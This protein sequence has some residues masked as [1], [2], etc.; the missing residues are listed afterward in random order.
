MLERAA[1][2]TIIETILRTAPAAAGILLALAALVAPATSHALAPRGGWRM[3]SDGVSG[4][5]P[6]NVDD[7]G[8][9]LMAVAEVAQGIEDGIDFTAEKI[10]V[11]LA[12]KRYTREA[13]ESNA[14]L[15]QFLSYNEG[16]QIKNSTDFGVN[17]RLPNLEKKWQLRFSSFDEREEERRTSQR[18]IRTQP[19][20]KEYGAAVRFFRQLGNVKA[21]FQPRLELR[22]PLEMS[23][24]LRFESVGE[25]KRLRVAPKLEL[26]ADAEKGT[27]QYG[28]FNVNYDL[29]KVWELLFI[30]DEEYRDFDNLLTVNNGASISRHLNDQMSAGATLM[31]LS[32]NR[33]L[34]NLE[35]YTFAPGFSHILAVD[36]IRYVISPYIIFARMNSWK[37]VTGIS[38]NFDVTF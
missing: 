10:D 4:N 37:G 28:S 35:Q 18:Y 26:F 14:T 30:N 15:T 24:I 6:N 22:D 23:Y 9:M 3:S 29:T 27:G 2:G 31:F 8:R 36:R 16:G 17:L 38:V 19:R 7:T 25:R 34:Y 20:E 13:N 32:T 5:F 21:T 11:M 1:N 33:P 12:G